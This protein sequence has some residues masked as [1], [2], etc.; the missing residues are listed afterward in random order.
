M[1]VPRRGYAGL[2]GISDAEV[3]YAIKND[4]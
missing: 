3:W 1:R 2:N 4:P